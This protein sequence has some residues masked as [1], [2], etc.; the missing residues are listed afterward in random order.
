[1]KRRSA[2]TLIELL[3]VIAIIAILA[4]ILFPVF[5]Q[6]REAA[7]K[8]TCQSNLKQIGLALRMYSNDY[9]EHWF[10][11]GAL[12]QFPATVADGS[13]LIRNLGGGLAYFCQPYVKN[14]G[15]FKCPSDPGDD[16]WTR[17]SNGAYV[18]SI[19]W[20]HPTSYMYRHIWDCAGPRG[21][22]RVGMADASLAFPANQGVF[23]ELAAWH[24]EKKSL[25]NTEQPLT[26][27]TVNMAYADGHV[28]V[29]KL[30]YLAPESWNVNFDMNWLIAPSGQNGDPTIGKDQNS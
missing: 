29:Y 25:W 12:P 6:A 22:P 4:A 27:R 20:G 28:K 26:T 5:A 30:N 14:Y 1:M 10:C 15:I 16:Y 9:D 13:N 2:F 24:A 19:W 11:S 3:V 18:S 8:T 7:R 23:V 17:N 21:D